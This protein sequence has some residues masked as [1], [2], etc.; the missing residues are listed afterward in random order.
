MHI[1]ARAFRR[2]ALCGASMLLLEIP[3]YDSKDEPFL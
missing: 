2:D 1:R 3:L